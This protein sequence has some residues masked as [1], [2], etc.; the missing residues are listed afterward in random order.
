V[1]GLRGLID[2]GSTGLVVP[3][4]S[5]E[6]L[7]AAIIE[8]LD[9]PDQ[10]TLMGSRGQEATCARFDV[11][12]EADLLASLYRRHATLSETQAPQ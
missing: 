4:G 5:P 7:A 11:E 2:H 6:S 1:K 12:I 10:A 3:P 9:H 8:L